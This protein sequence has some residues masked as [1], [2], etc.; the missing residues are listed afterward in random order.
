VSAIARRNEASQ[1]RIVFLDFDGVLILW[2]YP[3]GPGE[4]LDRSRVTI[5][6]DILAETGAM[7]VVTSSHRTDVES[8]RRVLGAAG[9]K[10]PGER[11]IGVTPSLPL[12][13]RGDEIGAWIQQH[14]R[15]P[16]SLCIL[17]DEDEV[18]PYGRYLVRTD[19][20]EGLTVVV[21]ARAKEMLARPARPAR[22]T[23]AS[24]NEK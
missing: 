14:G 9:L 17:D 21:A 10:C 6:G 15:V 5:L 4:L 18:E 19:R 7:V 8:M 1:E 3:P 22:R 11:V 23:R 20:G 24:T 12:A 2:D 16:D 13:P